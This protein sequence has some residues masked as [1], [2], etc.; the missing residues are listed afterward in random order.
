MLTVLWWGIAKKAKYAAWQVIE[1]LHRGATAT[2]VYARH[3]VEKEG[4][5]RYP[6][7]P[8]VSRRCGDAYSAAFTFS[9]VIGSER[10]RA[11]EAA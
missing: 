8:S 9:A 4:R 6:A 7:A 2:H 10:T 5:R 1:A 3:M 11:P